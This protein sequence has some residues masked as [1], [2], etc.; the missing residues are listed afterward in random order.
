VRF[1]SIRKEG[2]RVNARADRVLHAGL[3]PW[4]LVAHAVRCVK[5]NTV[6]V[7]MREGECTRTPR[8]LR[9]GPRSGIIARAV[10]LRSRAPHSSLDWNARSRTEPPPAPLTP[11][12]RTSHPQSPSLRRSCAAR[13]LLV[14]CSCAARPR[15]LVSRWLHS[16]RFR[17]DT[18]GT[19]DVTMMRPSCP[20]G[21]TYGMGL[22]AHL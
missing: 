10:H 14:C 16:L 15:R 19:T 22:S 3:L 4:R 8:T 17:F 21:S 18:N 13:V 9:R 6:S 5:A 7:F 2:W 12:R 11:D 1:G 20:S